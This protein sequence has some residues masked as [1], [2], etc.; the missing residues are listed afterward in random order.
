MKRKIAMFLAVALIWCS[1]PSAQPVVSYA[2]GGETS[3]V[4]P[5]DVPDV[6]NATVTWNVEGSGNVKIGDDC[7]PQGN[8]EVVS[9][10]DA[11]ITM[12]PDMGSQLLGLN[13]DGQ[14]CLWEHCEM[15]DDGYY[16]YTIPT[17]VRDTHV[18]V[19]FGTI[20]EDAGAAT[21]E[22]LGLEIVNQAGASVTPENG[23]TYYG[24]GLYLRGTGDTVYSLTGAG[25]YA[26]T[27]EVNES[28]VIENIYGRPVNPIT[29]GTEKKYR[30]SD[31][32]IMVI[33]HVKPEIQLSYEDNELWVEGSVNEITISAIARDE[34]IAYAVWSESALE[35]EEIKNCAN[36]T[37]A[38]GEDG[39]FTFSNLPLESDEKTI[40]LYVADKAGNYSDE[41]I[42]KV[43][44]DVKAAMVTDAEI[45]SDTNNLPYGTFANGSFRF[46][47]TAN[48]VKEENQ[49]W[50]HPSG[51][52]K[53][54]VYIGNS[55]TPAL[56]HPVNIRGN[57]SCEI[58]ITID[59]SQMLR[60]GMSQL[61]ELKVRV[62]D[63]TGNVSR[64]YR[65]SEFIQDFSDFIMLDKQAPSIE[66]EAASELGN[67][68]Q[69]YSSVPAINYRVSDRYNGQ[70]GSGLAERTI[71]LN[72]TLLQDCSRD[73]YS[74][75]S[76]Y[77]EVLKEDAGIIS[78]EQLT[79]M[80]Q[81]ENEVLVSFRDNAGNIGKS[82]LKVYLDSNV[83]TV[84]GYSLAVNSGQYSFGNFYNH[85]VEVTVYVNDSLDVSGNDIPSSGLKEVTLYLDGR[86]YET[87]T[88]I[89]DG[90]AVFFL[91]EELVTDEEKLYLSAEIKASVTD[92]VNNTS[93]IIDMTSVENGLENGRI[94]I[95]TVLPELEIAGREVAYQPESDIIYVKES[96][97]LDI[98]A[99]DV[100][101]G[102][103]GVEVEINGQEVVNK[104]YKEKQVHRDDLHVSTDD[105]AVAERYDLEISAKDNA[106]N[107]QV[108]TFTIFRD[109]TAPVIQSFEVCGDGRVETSV[110][111][112]VSE[113]M[114]YRHYFRGDV[115]V[116]I[117][118]MDGDGDENC[119]VKAIEYYTVDD[120]GIKTQATLAEVDSDG[121]VLVSIPGRFKG[122]LYARA[123]DYLGNVSES[124]VSMQGIVVEPYSSHAATEH[125]TLSKAVTTARDNSGNELY[126]GAV[127]VQVS[128]KDAISGIQRV[129][130][131][132]QAPFDSG[133]NAGGVLSIDN[134][135]NLEAGNDGWTRITTERNL[136]TE[137]QK[138]ILVSADS[139]D[140]TLRVSM[141]DCAGNVT[142]KTIGF[143]IDTTAPVMELSF[144]NVTP[145][146]EYTDVYRQARTATI[147]VKERNFSPSGIEAIITNTDG[148]VPQISEWSTKVDTANPDQT[149]STAKILFAEDGDYTL[150]LSARD[151]AGN[152]GGGVS[153]PDFT[154]DGTVPQVTVS[155]DNNQSLHG[156]YYAQERIATIRIE[157]HNFAPERVKV[158]GVITDTAENTVFPDLSEWRRDGDVYMATLVCEADGIYQFGV[159]YADKAGNTGEAYIG[160]QYC[161]DRKSPVVSFGG[162]E[163]CS[164]N[165]G[166]VMPTVM[167]TDENYDAESV[168]IKLIG[169]NRGIVQAEATVTEIAGGRLYT[170]ADFPREQVWDDLYSLCVTTKDL[171]GNETTETLTF[172]VNRFG[173][174]Y[175]FDES[176]KKLSGGYVKE[177]VTV[178]LTEV[179]ID[180][181]EHETIRVSVDYNG[182]IRDLTE[183]TDYVVKETGGEGSWYR[184]EY[185]IYSS[186]FDGDGRYIVTIYS[187]DKAGNKNR[188]IA[189]NKA[190]EIS[191]GVDRTEPVIIPIDI[192]SNTQ[193]PVDVKTATV[194]VN[195]NLVLDN[196][197]IYLDGVM[198][199][200]TVEGENYIFEI[201]QNNEHR[202]ITV[203]AYDAAGNE[204]RTIIENV[205]VT[206]DL[207][208]RWLNNRPLMMGTIAGAVVLS[209]GGVGAGVLFRRRRRTGKR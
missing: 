100:H 4:S 201:P 19:A 69:W 208:A 171:A 38:F 169:A 104:Q 73:D 141:T 122:H 198:C 178:K 163:D 53:V 93:E 50:Y 7:S 32:V 130:W 191:F 140:I 101:S 197:T 192:E 111:N 34:N 177:D 149:V 72:G 131:L 172:S 167:L 22:S 179:N 47:I 98:S 30:L 85:A 160:Q 148:P 46:R 157:E 143:S 107:L 153:T 28:V 134:N 29:F 120:T 99:I 145:D 113:N 112:E 159:E 121:C 83:P 175:V 207:L 123:Y 70:D 186:V 44:R 209:G 77:E 176:L 40:Y 133:K 11:V 10:G 62:I 63:R 81:G 185:Q 118:A 18:D 165:N 114:P 203:V 151:M 12:I 124:Y 65:L 102:L 116:R 202:T 75:V 1:I 95:E 27:I 117:Q 189:E 139:N 158:S 52:N 91:P 45:L 180:M 103:Q 181:L 87:T 55:A 58:E 14:V 84:T 79:G 110:V 26:D 115:T 200:Y 56:E 152:N 80:V 168:E 144:D 59:E 161:I 90:K 196:V 155:F 78:A 128:V 173:S 136:V 156:I 190:A 135:G 205:L 97:S 43:Y 36:R 21:M 154:I 60:Y 67:G 89:V 183:G 129:E 15:G 2:A 13:V 49:R 8:T 105:V 166:T 68:Q 147:M 33:D 125:I 150:S 71:S 66:L 164:A 57:Q 126:A 76:S 42:L 37:E 94:M 9:G 132:V 194:A 24:Q 48:D 170:W 108:D 25:I 204:T 61:Q 82:S 199:G 6:G 127:S 138:N 17:V 31:A 41:A 106:G 184:Y 51:I 54:K 96:Q 39:T 92:N 188:N 182:N 3:D 193:Y 88:D 146:A 86:V 5:G 187:E 23:N 64:D 162:V 174:V 142:E 195:D 119:G 35:A 16:T 74:Q 109:G 20:L 137:V 206:T